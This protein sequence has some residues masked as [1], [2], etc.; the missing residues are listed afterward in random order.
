MNPRRSIAAIAVV[1]MLG[2][3]LPAGAAPRTI[4]TDLR[5]T[6]V[7]VT[8][9]GNTPKKFE[10]FHPSW[11]AWIWIGVGGVLFCGLARQARK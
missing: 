1:T 4:S 6:S 7:A 9:T 5:G 10:G 3:A 2:T 8:T 11:K